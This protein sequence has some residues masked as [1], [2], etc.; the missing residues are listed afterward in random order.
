[1]RGI[2]LLLKNMPACSSKLVQDFLE[3]NTETLPHPPYLSNLAQHVTFFSV[4][5]SHKILCWS[6]FAKQLHSDQRVSSIWSI[7]QNKSRERGFLACVKRLRK[8]VTAGGEYFYWE[9]LLTRNCLMC[10]F[11][12]SFKLCFKWTSLVQMVTHIIC[13][14]THTQ[15]HIYVLYNALKHGHPKIARQSPYTAICCFRRIS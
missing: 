11:C 5:L 8:C 10:I 15:T 14:H 1:M 7:H 4:P 12:S 13:T 9:L 3:K 2:K 6:L